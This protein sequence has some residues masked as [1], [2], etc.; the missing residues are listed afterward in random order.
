ML[1]GVFQMCM[2]LPFVS[3][4]TY[5]RSGIFGGEGFKREY[6]VHKKKASVPR[7]PRNSPGQGPR[8]DAFDNLFCTDKA[9]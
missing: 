4:E 1:C 9:R 2:I 5:R 8:F 6:S 7:L 3:P